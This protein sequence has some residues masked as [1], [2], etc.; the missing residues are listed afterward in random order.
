MI[1][2]TFLVVVFFALA[3]ATCLAAE[4]AKRP[5]ILFCFADDF[6]RHTSA[7]AKL[8]P[9]GMND[10]V[11]TPAF[12]LLAREGVLFRNAF[13]GSPSCTPCRSALLSGQYFWRTGRAAIL[14]GAVWNPEI[15]AFPL[16]L[17]KN[18]YHIGKMYKVWSPGMPADA[19]FG[20]QKF[21]YQKHGNRFNQFS[22]NVT[23]MVAAGKPLDEAKTELYI[24]VKE[25]FDDF[26]EARPKDK[27]FC[28]WFGPTNV[29][30]KWVRGSGKALWGIDPEKL[31]GKLP[32]FLPDVPEVREDVADYFGE[33]QAFDK[34]VSWLFL[35]LLEAGELDNTIIVMSG[36]HGAPGFPH[37]KCNL[38]DFGT[39][40]S[41]AIRGPG[42]PKGRVLDDFVL[43]PDL[44]ATFLD[45][46]GVER[47]KEMT[48]KS[49]MPVL[50]SEKSGQVDPERTW[51]ITG[52][53]RHVESARE[54]FVPYP[55]RALRTQEY[56]Y[57]LNFE[58]DRWPMGDPYQLEGDKTPDLKLLAD[59]T[60]ITLKDMDASP[61]KA[62]LIGQRKDPQWKRHYDI[63]FAKRP[64]EELFDLKSDPHQVKN[65]AGD[66]AYAE[67]KNNL[68]KRLMD[69]LTRTGDPRV[70]GD[71]QFFEKPPMAGPLVPARSG[72]P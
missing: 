22:Q 26:L 8:Q 15:P 50:K 23:K 35:R 11:T 64:R 65:V 30:R 3:P 24:E 33:I 5:N 37:G 39:G 54:G 66:P 63:A 55:H 42:I 68:N 18:G 13:V 45:A 38:Y 40:V 69:E 9:G 28:F 34:A 71:R 67:E 7:Y 58:P 62:W 47:P 27:P 60:R 61:T 49:L 53:E 72:K 29:H 16:L 2:S 52:R 12:D 32:L 36:D 17:E 59:D 4:P 46:G 14:Q 1:R 44:A 43:L 56:L 51:V 19:P 57:I 70:T 10:L 48:A 6:G 31:K 20:G 21:A 41:L 25:N